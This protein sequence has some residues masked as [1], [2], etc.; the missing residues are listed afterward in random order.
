MSTN[1]RF[2]SN[3]A[4]RRF[5]PFI[6]SIFLFATTSFATSAR[7]DAQPSTLRVAVTLPNSSEQFDLNKSFLSTYDIVFNPL[8]D[9]LIMP[10]W[11]GK[12][13][14]RTARSIAYSDDGKSVHIELR[15]DSY[16]STG[17]RVIASDYVRGLQRASMADSNTAHLMRGIQNS[18]RWA[19]GDYSQPLGIEALDDSTIIIRLEGP[20][21]FELSN[22]MNMQANPYPP[23]PPNPGSYYP[24]NGP[25]ML[26][27]MSD[28]L[29]SLIRNPYYRGQAPHFDRIEFSGFSHD[30]AVDHFLSKKA[31]VLIG[32]LGKQKKWLLDRF[33]GN[34]IE[35]GLPR[36]YFIVLA[37]TNDKTPEALMD[38]N[39]RRALYF[40]LDH[41][42]FEKSN[43]FVGSRP[44]CGFIPA[45]IACSGRRRA[46]WRVDETMKEKVSQAKAV[47]ERAGYS[48]D[49]PLRISLALTP[50]IHGYSEL[51]GFV[52]SSWHE[53]GIEVDLVEFPTYLESIKAMKTGK[54][55]MQINSF[56]HLSPHQYIYRPEVFGEWALQHSPSRGNIDDLVSRTARATETELPELVFEAEKTM[57]DEMT[58]LPLVSD[59]QV[60]LYADWLSPNQ[61]NVAKLNLR[62]FGPK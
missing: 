53:I 21:S 19:S 60:A 50:S 51:A 23:T 18:A 26:E 46:L 30:L 29:I 57:I 34:F 36:K 10:D 54:Y 48:R 49:N 42:S 28:Q 3:C 8:F 11:N 14:M 37:A 61:N 20:F 1:R 15:D 27:G 58:S 55:M 44:H 45:Q 38:P 32:P 59:S 33:K 13:A 9:R 39:F 17:D 52:K 31:D 24:S 40:A 47:V 12:R 56:Y 41:E 35:A 62:F 16:W 25:Y 2:G 22:L 6:V 43:I 7:I 4:S 5:A